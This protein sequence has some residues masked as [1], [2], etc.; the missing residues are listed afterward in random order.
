M[1][2]LTVRNGHGNYMGNLPRT[3]C[4]ALFIAWG[5]SPIN[6]WV[7]LSLTPW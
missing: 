1:I 4:A 5:K 7:I 3:G 2:A 6:A